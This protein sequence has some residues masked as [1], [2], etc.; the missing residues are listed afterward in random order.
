M[1]FRFQR[2]LVQQPQTELVQLLRNRLEDISARTKTEQIAKEMTIEMM[3]MGFA[4]MDANHI[5]KA[6]WATGKWPNEMK[7]GILADNEIVF[8]LGKNKARSNFFVFMKQHENSIEIFYTNP[9]S[10]EVGLVF[11]SDELYIRRGIN[12]GGANTGTAMRKIL[13]EIREV[14]GG[15]YEEDFRIQTHF[16]ARYLFDFGWRLADD[17]ASNM[18]DIIR[19]AMMT[20]MD[21]FNYTPHNSSNM[22][23]HSVLN[24]VLGAVGMVYIPGTELTCTFARDGINGPHRILMFDGYE[25][26]SAGDIVRRRILSKRNGGLEMQSYFRG[27]DIDEMGAVIRELEDR[28]MLFSGFAHPVNCNTA[29][30]PILIVG[31]LSAVELG[32]L[33]LDQAIREIKRTGAIAALNDTL[34]DTDLGEILTNMELG[35]WL[36]SLISKQ[37]LGKTITT[38]AAALAVGNWA[39]AVLGLGTFY[40]SD[41]HTTAPMNDYAIPGDGF[42]KGFTRILLPRAEYRRMHVEERK[43]TA[44]E[45]V[46]LLCE[47]KATMHAKVFCEMDG[48]RVEFPKARSRGEEETAMERFWLKMKKYWYYFKALT[49]D[50]IY[51]IRNREFKRL[52]AMDK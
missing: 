13:D 3:R 4:A 34:E 41:T 25:R 50:A 2:R 46:K 51:F 8:S 43:P 16:H 35:S 19:A 7:T 52:F 37:G 47:E 30:M 38:H 12:D 11:T 17:G 26:G 39:E 28:K 36:Y 31:I 21:G 15:K 10:D 49:H 20:H 44:K 1:D 6:A 9:R 5:D 22:E 29:S 32:Y 48:G 18:A 24:A 42:M 27:M 14:A 33:T 40:E 23:V 45:L